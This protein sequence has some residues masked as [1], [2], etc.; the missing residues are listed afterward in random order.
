MDEQEFIRR[1]QPWFERHRRPAW[2]PTVREGDGPPEASKFSGT[3]LLEAGETWPA[4][5]AC[6]SPMPLFL[7]LNLDDLPEE[8]GHCFGEGW[9]Q[10]FYCANY[11]CECD[12]FE[13]FSKGKLVRII[14]P[15]H[16]SAEINP[17]AFP[18]PMP[19]RAITG[20]DRF[21]DHPD[22]EEQEDLGLSRRYISDPESIMEMRVECPELNLV[23]EGMQEFVMDSL[24]RCFERD[25]LA[26]W[27]DWLQGMEY[28]DCPKCGARMRYVFQLDAEDHLPYS[29]GDS[30]RGHITQCPAHPH[31]LAFGWAC[32]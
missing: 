6:H 31:I 17:P 1:L 22:Y 21:D 24:D 7:Q 2:R 19:P 26:G 23:Y 16:A 15:G 28:P 27:P 5:A 4:C 11:K 8:L 30:G 18:D 25:K 3:P 29:F 32:C 14:R 10:L 13:P 12:N 20:W 9:L